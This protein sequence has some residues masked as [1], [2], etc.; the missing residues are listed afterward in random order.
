[1]VV[2]RGVVIEN[3]HE[4]RSRNGQGRCRREKIIVSLESHH[5]TPPYGGRFHIPGKQ[6]DPQAQCISD[7]GE[8]SDPMAAGADLETQ[9]ADDS[10]IIGDRSQITAQVMR[11]P[12][13]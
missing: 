5:H 1:V 12:W 11:S 10:I 7:D 4:G 8:P 13:S 3:D 2:N 9:P 6:R